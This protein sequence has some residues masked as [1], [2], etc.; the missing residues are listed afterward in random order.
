[1]S[2]AGHILDM[3]IRS[4][5]NEALRKSRRKRY[6]DIKDAYLQYVYQHVKFEDKIS[7]SEAEL[8][9]IKTK[10]RAKIIKERRIVYLKT[11]FTVLI[12]VGL[13]VALIWR[14]V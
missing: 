3:I 10:I 11:T 2:S 6:A 14:M 1:M 4:R 7:L 13:F 9:V 8:K 5:N 12:I